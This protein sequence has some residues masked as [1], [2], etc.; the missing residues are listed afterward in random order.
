[1]RELIFALLGKETVFKEKTLADL[2]KSFLSEGHVDLNYTVFYP[3]QLEP[4]TFQDFVHTQPFLS[5]RRLVV[6]R[7]V[8]RL[9]LLTKDSVINY[10]KNPSKNTVLVLISELDIKEINPKKDE[11]FATI[12][13][14]AKV[15][16]FEPLEGTKLNNYLRDKIASY[17]KTITE[18]AVKLLIEKMGNDLGFL[19]KA[20][21]EL[22]TYVGTKPRIDRA[23]VEALIGR[24]LEESVFTLTNAICRRQEEQSLSILS[25]LL[26]ESVSPESIIGAIGAEFRRILRI[27]Y[28]MA[29]NRNPRQI[30]NELNLNWQALNESIRLAG[31]MKLDDI[32][33]SLEHILKADSDCKNKDVDKRV[34]LESLIVKLCDVG[35]LA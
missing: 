22:T 16:T 4:Q 15:Q 5:P 21:E 11:L 13:K 29:Q 24:S 6:I 27:K 31:L 2:K 10:I 14:Y 23:D 30:Q 33:K 17:K 25:N 19:K 20:I 28:L 7:D 9:S 26:D 8:E 32:K 12:L 3:D 1:M 34:V 18:D 35:E